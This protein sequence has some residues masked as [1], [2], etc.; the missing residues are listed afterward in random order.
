MFSMAHLLAPEL[1]CSH[2]NIEQKQ[3]HFHENFIMLIYYF[4]NKIKMH[5]KNEV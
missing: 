4:N 3:L 5:V 1:K 2:T